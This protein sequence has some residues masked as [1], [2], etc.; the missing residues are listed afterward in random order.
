M[1]PPADTFPPLEAL[2]GVRAVFL[3]R[4]PGVDVNT[5][6]DTAMARL[7]TLQRDALDE[8]GFRDM[9]LA[10][11]AQ[12]HGNSI[13]RVSRNDSFP[14]PDCDAL[15][16]TERGLC[17]GIH[18]ADCAAVYIADR[19]GRGIALAHA[20]KK[21]TQLGIVP[22]TISALIDATGASPSDLVLQISP[23]IRPPHY[24]IDFAADIRTQA[25]AVGIESIHD[26]GTCTA[27]DPMRYYSYRLE[28]GKTGRLLAALSLTP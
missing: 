16:T 10:R 17:L 23:C 14:I 6:R 15:L 7:A 25:S 27:S 26:C 9:P 3:T 24:E 1:I 21:G 28:K 13:A 12:I 18:V 20:G 5:D 2:A 11:A 19:Q 8:L 4:A 22:L